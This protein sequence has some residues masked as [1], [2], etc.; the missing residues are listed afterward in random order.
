M[1]NSKHTAKINRL[2]YPILIFSFPP[3][4]GTSY[5]LD[6]IRKQSLENKYFKELPRKNPGFFSH[7]VNHTGAQPAPHPRE[8]TS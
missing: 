2:H 6:E 5:K 3:C 1:A 4:K 7:M 8:T